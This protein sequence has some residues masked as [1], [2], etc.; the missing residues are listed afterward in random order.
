MLGRWSL[1]ARDALR[2]RCVR[3]RLA[4]IALAAVLTAMLAGAESAGACS[5]AYVPPKKQ[6][7][8]ADGAFTGRLL[9]VRPAEGTTEAAFRYRVGR[10]FKGRARLRRGEVV[11]VWSQNSDGLCGLPQGTG[12]IYGLFLSR[13]EGRWTSGT[14]A[15]LS[16]RKMRR[17]ARRDADSSGAPAASGSACA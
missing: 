10:A 17:A 6:M 12:V 3:T 16:P 9:S 7:K 14:C 1:R 4:V 13:R 5:C 11:T 8:R 15:V 2:S